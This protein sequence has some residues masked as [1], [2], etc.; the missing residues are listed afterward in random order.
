MTDPA[1]LTVRFGDDALPFVGCAH[2]DLVKAIEDAV[3][4][5]CG[6]VPVKVEDGYIFVVHDGETATRYRLVIE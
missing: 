1:T 6:D 3:S 4:E 2:V 5:Q